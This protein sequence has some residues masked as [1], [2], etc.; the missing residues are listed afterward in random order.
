MK[1]KLS[2]RL[3]KGFQKK[4]NIISLILLGLFLVLLIF[5]IV[6]N[7]EYRDSSIAKSTEISG[8][9]GDILTLEKDNFLVV[10]GLNQGIDSLVSLRVKKDSLL[11]I[12]N[13]K[14]AQLKNSF[15]IS[16][17]EWVTQLEEKDSLLAYA[18][19]LET[20]FCMKNAQLECDLVSA[21]EKI[22]SLIKKNDSLAKET[23]AIVPLQV[24]LKTHVEFLDYLSQWDRNLTKDSGAC[25]YNG[26]RGFFQRKVKPKKIMEK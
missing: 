23:E 18:D 14:I 19:R 16:T 6:K 12:K 17:K 15:K 11:R 8:L 5:V 22:E 2:L 7:I 13:E 26:K 9:K 20:S 3:N 4:W 25:I 21:T 10:R 1:K 24:K